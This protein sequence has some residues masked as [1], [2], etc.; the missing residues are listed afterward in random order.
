[1]TRFRQTLTFRVF[2]CF[3]ANPSGR[4]SVLKDKEFFEERREER[5]QREKQHILNLYYEEI[6]G[7]SFI[8]HPLGFDSA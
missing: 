5:N 2:V 7:E 4:D 6:V 1:M 3:T 8:C